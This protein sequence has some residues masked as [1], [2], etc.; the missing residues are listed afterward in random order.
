M[1]SK[2]SNSS[3]FAHV[4][5]VLA[6]VVLVAVVGTGVYVYNHGKAKRQDTAANQASG[7]NTSPAPKD[8]ASLNTQ[9]NQDSA[10]SDPTEGG[11]YLVITEWGVRV[12]LPSDLKG[13]VTYSLGAVTPDPDGNQI[14]VAK[15]LVAS[16]AFTENACATTTTSLG[17]AIESG[18][19]YIRSETSKP[20]NAARYRW[21]FKENIL[22]NGNY[23]Y[24]LNYVTPDCAGGG[25][26]ASKI[27]ELQSALIQ[28][29]K[30]E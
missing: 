13:A 8:E 19:Q 29:Q 14:Q 5:G 17:T 28:L 25:T 30:L 10:P 12:T 7:T 15:V 24:H 20:F 2:S 9:Q 3:G 21:T 23:A 22:T 1:N 16:T 4:A 27:E 18:A 6:I 11:K 26:N